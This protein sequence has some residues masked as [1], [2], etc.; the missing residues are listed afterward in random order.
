MRRMLLLK[1]PG[2]KLA[3]EKMD[4]VVD[5]ED[6]RFVMKVLERCRRMASGDGA[7]TLVLL[8]L[9][10]LNVRRFEIWRIKRGGV[11]DLG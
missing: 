11:V 6:T 5:G 4:V 8:G 2:Q 10:V 9:D 3:G 7:K 1:R